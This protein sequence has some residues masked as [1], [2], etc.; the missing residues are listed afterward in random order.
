METLIKGYDESTEIRRS[1]E[2]LPF[3]GVW[4]W[5]TGKE[6]LNR[7]QLL[8]SQKLALR[9]T[10]DYVDVWGLH[11]CLDYVFTMISNADPV[12]IHE[13]EYRLN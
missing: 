2:R 7:D 8:R 9:G 11:H 6:I 1:Y 5:L 12:D 3:Q 10:Y 4:T 13:M